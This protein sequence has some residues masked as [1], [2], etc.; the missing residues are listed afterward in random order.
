MNKIYYL[1]LIGFGLS[2][3]LSGGFDENEQLDE[4]NNELAKAPKVESISV[5]GAVV[6]RNQQSRRV[7]EAKTGDVLN[8]DVKLTSGKGA[9]LEELEFF[10]VYYYLEGFQEDPKPVDPN[11]QGVYPISGAQFDF[12]YSYT[13][14]EED[15]DGFHFDPGYIIQVYCRAKNSLGNYGYKAIEIHIVE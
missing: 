12:T 11:T 14:P 4:L 2:S 15:D 8:F 9:T 6:E 3:C 5:N 7:I 13:V 1:L 10:R